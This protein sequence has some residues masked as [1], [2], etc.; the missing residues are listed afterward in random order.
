MGTRAALLIGISDY[1]VEFGNIPESILDLQKIKQVLQDPD[2]GDYALKALKNLDNVT[3]QS[4][5]EIFFADRSPDDI[6]LLYFVGHGVLGSD[7][8]V[9]QPLYL[10]PANAEKRNQ[11]LVESTAIS[12]MFLKHHLDSS[13]AKQIMVILECCVESAIA[14][15]LRQSADIANIYSLNQEGQVVLSW[16]RERQIA[17][18]PVEGQSY[19]TQYLIEGMRG[20]VHTEEAW[21]TA[22]Q[23]CHYIE[24]RFDKADQS[25]PLLSFFSGQTGSHFPIVK[26]PKSHLKLEYRKEVDRIFRELDQE[27]YL[28]FD[29]EIKDPLDL[30]S[31][32]TYRDRCKLNVEEAQLI[33]KQV[34]KTYLKQAQNRQKYATYVKTIAQ[35]PSPPTPRALKRLTEIRSNLGLGD[36]DTKRIEAEFGLTQSH[37]PLHFQTTQK[38]KQQPQ[39]RKGQNAT[40]EKQPI[41][42]DPSDAPHLRY[43]PL[44]KYLKAQDWKA[45]DHE[46]YRLMI[47]QV[48]KDEG[49]WFQLQELLTYPCDDMMKI[50]QCWVQYS[51]GKFGFSVQMK[52][53]QEC[54]SPRSYNKVWEK[55]GDCV[56]WRTEGEW[57]SYQ[58]INPSLDSPPGHFPMGGFTSDC[59]LWDA[60]Y[61]DWGWT[62]NDVF[63]VSLCL[64][65]S[66]LMTRFSCCPVRSIEHHS[67]V[68]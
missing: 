7:Q 24:Q 53:W 35:N 8:N 18:D 14:H 59:V 64:Y 28:E 1:G 43:Q 54:G 27:L 68:I 49:E 34:Q 22:Q 55:F 2:E 38:T 52:L 37:P 47:E 5:I 3:I 21:I 58:S 23:L 16:F 32:E 62:F 61:R 12:M 51:Q 44:E 10:C 30:G 50:D 29:G 20:G 63:Y 4:E 41:D 33:E 31:L 48:D 11:T 65:F 67:D 40:K 39:V 9:P 15:Q 17:L 66:S 46:T 42:Q 60:A 56:G 13:Q 26:A 25:H 45:A 19:F 6:L 57:L 36:Y